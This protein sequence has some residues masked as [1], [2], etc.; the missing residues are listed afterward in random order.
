MKQYKRSVKLYFITLRSFSLK[1]SL[2]IDGFV[3][4]IREISNISN[5]SDCQRN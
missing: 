2:K 3:P 5:L 1:L 4:T